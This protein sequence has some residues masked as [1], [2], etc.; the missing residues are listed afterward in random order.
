MFERHQQ[1][2][3]D[4]IAESASRA[5]AGRLTRR[6]FMGWLGKGAVLVAGGS[7]LVGLLASPAEA[8][9][10]GQS[11]VSPKCPNYDCIDAV[12]GWCWYAN[13][14]CAGGKLKKICDC[15]GHVDNVHGYCPSGVNVKCI[16]ESCGTDPRVQTVPISRIQSDSA[17]TMAAAFSRVRYGK[18][19]RP[20]VVL[21]N[22]DDS[23][24]SAIAAT[25]AGALGGPLLLTGPGGLDTQ[26]AAELQRLGSTDVKIVG[27]NIGSTVNS[28]LVAYGRTPDSM[29]S[30]NT[31]AALSSE[32][33][34]WVRARTG[35]N[36]A[37]CVD[38]SGTSFSMAPIAGAA[39]ASKGMML[40]V[41]VS[42]A[43]AKANNG[44]VLTYM[45]GPE[46]ADRANE[47]AGS[48]AVRSSNTVAMAAELA[49]YMTNV[50]HTN[51]STITLAPWAGNSGLAA[52]PGLVLLHGNPGS[53]DGARDWMFANRSGFRRAFAVGATGGLNNDGYYEAQSVVNGFDAHLLIGVA[54]QGLPVIEQPE[55]ERP[56]G[57]ARI[58]S[59][60]VSSEPTPYWTDRG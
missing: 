16:V 3:F 28:N 9:V 8:R 10:C 56:L 31:H 59:L 15:C 23:L 14:C 22:A 11:G 52:S 37:I 12:F 4:R 26:V 39:A 54:G 40:L 6:S 45:V 34:D 50:E 51:V 17:I 29:F 19:S 24:S 46:A 5:L 27:L 2:H 57:R 47:V 33:A 1:V 55:S 25:V 49:G 38:P 48:K 58:S 41:G 43:T 53:L 13:G 18:N 36:R 7:T 30:S 35:T 21:S 20:T 32:V 60:N 42:T 44:V